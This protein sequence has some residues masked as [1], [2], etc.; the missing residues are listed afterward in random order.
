MSDFA[1]HNVEQHVKTR[2]TA[3]TDEGVEAVHATEDGPEEPVKIACD[4]VVMAVGSKTNG[5]GPASAAGPALFV[6]APRCDGN[7]R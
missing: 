2:L 3:V 1:A 4:Y 6:F 5:A 7:A